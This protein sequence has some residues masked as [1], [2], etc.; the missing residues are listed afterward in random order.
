M[1]RLLVDTS[2]AEDQTQIETTVNNLISSNEVDS[3]RI[4]SLTITPFGAV[5]FLITLIFTGGIII[6]DAFVG[7]KSK[8]NFNY[9]KGA[10]AILLG[11]A[12]SVTTI[13]R[14]NRGITSNLGLNVALMG[15]DISK[16]LSS[17]IGLA[18]SMLENWI[19]LT[20]TKN[21]LIGLFPSLEGVLAMNRAS[22]VSIGLLPDVSTS[23]FVP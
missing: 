20:Q 5:Q 10:R 2:V 16:P 11:L 4:N 18:V 1:A 13:L 3:T 19:D 7:L 12:L 9:S 17:S 22:S 23:H 8:I 15:I 6:R 21:I 14:M